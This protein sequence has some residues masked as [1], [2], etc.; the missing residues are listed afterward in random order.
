MG[1]TGRRA[2]SRRRTRL[3]P[4]GKAHAQKPAGRARLAQMRIETDQAA[5]LLSDALAAIGAGREDAQLRVLEVKAASGEAAIDVTDL[6]MQICG[7]AA[8]RKGPGVRR[9]VPRATR[10]RG[11]AAPARPP[12]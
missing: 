4:L 2:A 6:A 5:A 7:G 3:A 12:Q 1:I 9:P 10:P 8:F 11:E